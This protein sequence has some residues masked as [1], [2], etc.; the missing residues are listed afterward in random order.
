MAIIRLKDLKALQAGELKEKLELYTK[1]LKEQEASRVRTKKP[2]NPG[3][4]R[5]LKKVI[6]RIHTL[7]GQ[8]ALKQEQAKPVAPKVQP[9]KTDS[10]V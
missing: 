5:E 1:E 8:K 2:D 7:T 6:A 3:K 10:K 4:Y 9:K